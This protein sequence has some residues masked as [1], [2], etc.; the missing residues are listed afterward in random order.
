VILTIIFIRR[1]REKETMKK[2]NYIYTQEDLDF[3]NE[4][5]SE[6]EVTLDDVI[7]ISEDML[8]QDS[9]CDEFWS[10]LNDNLYQS[11]IKLL[12]KNEEDGFTYI[13]EIMETLHYDNGQPLSCEDY[14]YFEHYDRDQDFW[15]F[16]N[17]VEIHHFELDS[18]NNLVVVVNMTYDQLRK[19]LT[20]MYDN[21]SY[22]H[23]FN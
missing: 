10:R 19:I 5:W 3:M 17:D 22:E 6:N 14:N 9:G 18:E 20:E 12:D 8:E 11:E 21:S 7:N 4:D 1:E 23:D 15:S 2:E 16:F 13:Q